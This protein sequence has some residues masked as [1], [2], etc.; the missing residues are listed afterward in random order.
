M[1]IEQLKYFA[2][3]EQVGNFSEAAE[4]LFTTQSTV[5]KQIKS[6]ENELGFS[7]FSRTSRKIKIT[8]AG[9]QFSLHVHRI[10]QEYDNMQKETL[11]YKGKQTQL[12]RILSI[13]V[14]A[15]YELLD[16][17][18]EFSS[19]NC[20]LSLQIEERDS[21]IVAQELLKGDADI[22]V[23]RSFHPLL[24]QNPLVHITPILDDELCLIINCAHPLASNEEVSLQ[25]LSKETFYFLSSHTGICNYCISECSKFGFIPNIQQRELS[26]YS[27]QKII[28]SSLAISFMARRVAES[29]QT[30]NIRVIP[31]KEHLQLDISFAT[32]NKNHD[33]NIVRLIT[34]VSDFINKKSKKN[35]NY[36]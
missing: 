1:T 25:D 27:L 5:S 22:A 8:P 35:I 20:D 14:L 3:I 19:I 4:L 31:L 15:Q 28:D 23:I 11:R 16:A 9:K 7:L 2:A 10:L 17:F 13:P 21:N 6:L 18:A 26:R 30:K 12:L 29:I 24:N 36:I 33:K 34:F 32:L